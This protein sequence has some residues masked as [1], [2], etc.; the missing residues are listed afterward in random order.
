ML[1]VGC[2]QITCAF[3]LRNTPVLS[4]PFFLTAY[5][6]GA[7]A[8]QNIFLGIHEVSHNLVFRSPLAN[9]LFA[10][11]ANLP[12]G[13]PY[14][15]LFRPYHLTHH[16][17]LGVNGYDTDL[18]T[19]LEAWLL[20]SV[21]GKAFF[22]TFQMFF[23]AFRPLF[24]YQVPF[25]WIQGL[26]FA[27][28]IVF[29][30]LIGFQFGQSALLYLIISSVLACSLHPCA[31]HFIAEHYVF[32]AASREL[33]M[34]GEQPRTETYSYYGPLNILTYNV[35]LHNEHHDLPAIPWSR[36]WQLHTI[37]NEFYRDLPQHRSWIGVL[38]C[39]IWDK[40]VGMLCRIKRQNGGRKIGGRT[41][42]HARPGFQ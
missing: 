35:G 6:V 34:S 32:D 11:V 41:E 1:A 7:T 2:L 10:V 26:N 27:A 18:P 40:N 30:C 31:G 4:W 16:K 38:W 28:Q 37:A 22:C 5:V 8:N 14:S 3:L 42:S 17:S 36:L 29:D 13:I 21:A 9:R 20:D 12:I 33:L 23:Y 39:F 24:I 19:G 25:A 15:A